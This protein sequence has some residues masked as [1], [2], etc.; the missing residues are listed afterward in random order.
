MREGGEEGR[1][2]TGKQAHMY[3]CRQIIL[4]DR[5]AYMQAVIQGGM[6]AGNHVSSRT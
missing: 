2:H 5:Q 3:S 6:Q 1:R 4:I